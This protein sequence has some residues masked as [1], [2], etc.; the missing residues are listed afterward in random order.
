[1][2]REFGELHDEVSSSFSKLMQQ[3]SLLQHKVRSTQQA[4][5][6]T[7]QSAATHRPTPALRAH[8]VGAVRAGNREKQ[9]R[10]REMEA[11]LAR[12]GDKVQRLRAEHTAVE[13]KNKTLIDQEE[14]LAA[15]R[16]GE[17]DQY[18]QALRRGARQ[19][20]ARLVSNAP[21]LPCLCVW[22]LLG[23]TAP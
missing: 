15:Q 12:E 4:A 20:Q 7:S 14:Q 16:E 23:G 3:H 10:I 21:P 1:M 2:V 5:D 11:T 6:A 8:S 19:M 18:V 17:L 9:T 13:L 22:P